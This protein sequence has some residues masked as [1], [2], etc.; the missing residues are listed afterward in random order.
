MR[1]PLTAAELAEIGNTATEREK[2]LL[3]EIHRLRSV[4]RRAN[5][6]ARDA[7][8]GPQGV[9]T[10]VWEAFVAEVTREPAVTDKPTPRQQAVIDAARRKR[11]GERN[12]S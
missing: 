10:L 4:I 11:E 2:K 5:Q 1:P 9:P 3:W 7:T 8:M 6:V 12:G